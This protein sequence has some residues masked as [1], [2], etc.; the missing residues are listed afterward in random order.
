MFAKEP[1]MVL[2]LTLTLG[3]VANHRLLTKPKHNSGL[4][5]LARTQNDHFGFELEI[6]L[7]LVVI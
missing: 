4:K 6:K 3:W 1:I 7:Y 2:T 5:L